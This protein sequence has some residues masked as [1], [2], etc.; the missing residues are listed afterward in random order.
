MDFIER[1]LHAV[2]F[3]LPRRQQDDMV[4]ELAEDLRAEM[5]ERESSLGRSLTEAEV[6]DLLR[7]RGSPILV[8]NRYLPQRQLIG[9][10]LLP[11]YVFVIKVVSACILIPSFFGWV[12]GFVSHAMGTDRGT[13]WGTRIG[14]AL[15]HLW[16]AWFVALGVVTLTFAILERVDAGQQLLSTW[17][18]RKLPPVRNLKTIPRSASLIEL[19]VG[20]CVL[21]WWATNMAS[22]LTLHLGVLRVTL[23]PV[24][25]WFFWSILTLTLANIVFAGYRLLRPWWTIPRVV[26][27]LLLDLAGGA[28]FCALLRAN[29]IAGITAHNL[30]PERSAAVAATLNGACAQIFPFAVLICLF[31][32]ASHVWRLIRIR[33]RAGEQTMHAAL[34]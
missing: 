8:A 31:V 6:Q 29:L 24:W 32:A 26:V 4:A 18:P 25:S 34:I 5:E 9:P 14:P 15:G 3:W 33:R 1:Y 17:N 10:L 23:A 30:P 28:V 27:S 20:V 16:T 2:K 7:R 21:V 22:P 12:A 19:A 11:L 13:I